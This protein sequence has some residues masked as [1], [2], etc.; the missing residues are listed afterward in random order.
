MNRKNVIKVILNTSS[1]G[2]DIARLITEFIHSDYLYQIFS[3]NSELVYLPRSYIKIRR[4]SSTFHQ[5]LSQGTTT[6]YLCHLRNGIKFGIKSP[7]MRPYITPV[8]LQQKNGVFY[9]SMND[10]IYHFVFIIIY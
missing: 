2:S 4:G 8:S 1:V 7:F 6:L 9:A 3:N 5:I 10:I